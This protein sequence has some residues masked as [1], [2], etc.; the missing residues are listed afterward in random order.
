MGVNYIAFYGTD[1]QV[2][3][4]AERS[5]K[6]KLLPV[7]SDFQAEFEAAYEFARKYV[8]SARKY[9]GH[10]QRNQKRAAPRGR[11]AAVGALPGAFIAFRQSQ[12][13]LSPSK[14]NV[15]VTDYS[16][17]L[18]VLHVSSHTTST[19]S[20]TAP[21]ADDVSPSTILDGL[22]MFVGMDA[23]ADGCQVPFSNES[24][25]PSAQVANLFSIGPYNA[26]QGAW[27]RKLLPGAKVWLQLSADFTAHAVLLEA[28]KPS[29]ASVRLTFLDDPMAGEADKIKRCGGDKRVSARNHA[30]SSTG[31][32]SGIA[33]LVS[34]GSNGSAVI[35]GADTPLHRW[36]AP[37]VQVGVGGFA[38]LSGLPAGVMGPA[39]IAIENVGSVAAVLHMV[40]ALV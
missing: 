5:L 35:R 27:A 16:T 10:S 34:V 38:P 20:A 32:R 12:T 6:G 17:Q 7:G 13:D 23:R 39:H 25:T 22:D 15:Q 14:Y 31:P 40:E 2:A 24:R 37:V 8:G 26:R 29:N 1:L 19:V 33:V 11:G 36:T 21:D 18:K 28:S 9:I 3:W 30:G 4:A